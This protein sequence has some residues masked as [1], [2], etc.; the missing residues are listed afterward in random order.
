MVSLGWCKNLLQAV[1][2]GVLAGP[3]ALYLFVNSIASIGAG[4][5]AIFFSPAD[6]MSQP[7]QQFQTTQR[8]ADNFN[9]IKR[10]LFCRVL[11]II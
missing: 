8:L 2:E 9:L 6:F 10:R 7:L 3:L 1:L 11:G 5:A 4:R